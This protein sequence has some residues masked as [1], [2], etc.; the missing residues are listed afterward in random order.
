MASKQPVWGI[1]VGQCS[2]KAIKLQQNGDQV[3]MLTCDV[4]EHDTILSQAEADA[5]AMVIKAIAT[6]AQRNDLKG[7]RVVISVPGQQTLTRFTKMPPVEEKKI[8]DMVQYEASQQIPFDMDEVVWDYQVFKEKD[9]PDV[10]VG[11]FAIRKELIRNYIAYFTDAGIEPFIVQTSPMASYN[12]AKYESV[13]AEGKAAVLLDMGALA[14]DLIVIEGN[15]IWSRPVPI[16]GN[17]FTEALV[18][19][20]KISFRKAEK[21]KRTAATSKYARQVFQAMRPV[22]ADLVSEIQRSIGFYTS[23]HR[24]A[25]VTRVIGM[26]NAFLLPG[27]QKFLTQNLQIEVDRLTGFKKMIAPTND[28]TPI[29][30]ANVMSFGVAYGLAL[31]GMGLA[32]VSS[33]LIPLE[34]KKSLLWK[35][36]QTWFY[37]AAACLA[38]GA[39]S[40]WVSNVMATNQIN[41]M[42]GGLPSATPQSASSVNDAMLKIN[43]AGSE[44]PVAKAAKIAGAAQKLQS[45][46]GDV[47]RKATGDEAFLKTIAKLPQSNMLVPRIVETIHRAF[48]EAAPS[49]AAAKTPREYIEVAQQTPRVERK[50]VWIE[51]LV[52]VYDPK[53]PERFFSSDEKSSPLRSPGWYVRIVGCTTDPKPA[54]WIQS[55][56][57]AALDQVGKEPKR[58]YYFDK[59][60]LVKASPRSGSKPVQNVAVENAGASVASR[61]GRGQVPTGREESLLGPMSGRG[62][63]ASVGGGSVGYGRSVA[64]EL[65]R[66][67]NK[68]RK[69]DPLT[70][71]EIDKDQRFI[72][73]FVVRKA[74]TPDKIIPERFKPKQP[75]KPEKKKG[76]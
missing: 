76:G 57:I 71:E 3:E 17:R 39:A 62:A 64:D 20:F 8:P 27:L 46:F 67:K 42:M 21:L 2:L 19:A 55:S 43:S 47:D 56:L 48:G 41:N 69:V 72:L 9:S 75:E 73:Q 61:S 60:T 35:K 16:G 29:F 51:D 74:D 12:T 54:Q 63:G 37:G 49:L 26:G 30:N 58:G 1:D 65:L 15:R 38:L 7:S 4:V 11:I 34:T 50:D 66:W 45:A 31:Q 25:H 5:T 53:D 36:K 23:T 33:N 13:A 44:A 32:S 68:F 14:T 22:F 59:I 24:E 10:E 52:M 6:F 28:R 70:N 18:A 40:I